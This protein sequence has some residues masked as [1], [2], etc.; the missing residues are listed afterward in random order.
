MPPT[1]SPEPKHEHPTRAEVA[2][3]GAEG[4]RQRQR[5]ARRAL[6]KDVDKL[7]RLDDGVKDLGLDG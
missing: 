3:G 5:E 1:R 4:A 2:G 6:V 7:K